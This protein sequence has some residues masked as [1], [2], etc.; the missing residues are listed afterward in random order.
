MNGM[1]DSRMADL[2]RAETLVGQSLAA[3]PRYASPHYVK[4]EVLRA[5]GRYE[6]AIPEYETA[7]PLNRNLMV[8]L[9]GLAWCK[10]YA[11]YI[12]EVIPLEE[13]SIR[14]SPREPWIGHCYYLIG[15]VHLLQ[16]RT[17]EAIVWF[18]KGCSA[19]PGIAFHHS[20]LAAA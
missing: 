10:L 14:L 12:E 3:S 13:Q 6:E 15:T 20:R 9:T 7:L 17:D 8:A 11:G 1:S 18:E 4:G 5:Q 16:S 19:L 2:A